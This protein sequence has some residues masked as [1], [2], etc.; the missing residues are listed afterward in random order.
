MHIKTLMQHPILPKH[1]RKN[2]IGMISK[3]LSSQDSYLEEVERHLAGCTSQYFVYKNLGF[4]V[5]Y[6]RDYSLSRAKK[7]FAIHCFMYSK[8]LAPKPY[9]LVH[10]FM[11]NDEYYVS[12]VEHFKTSK[13]SDIKQ[14]QYFHK[15]MNKAHQYGIY[16]FDHEICCNFLANRDKGILI[17]FD[18]EYIKITYEQTKQKIKNIM[19][20]YSQSAS[21]M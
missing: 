21:A 17:D 14:Q 3:V 20:K 5:T 13:I 16:L 4:R 12:I 6:T 18:P 15:V 7:D 9:V 10:A 11:P 8:R 19:K 1:I 2:Y